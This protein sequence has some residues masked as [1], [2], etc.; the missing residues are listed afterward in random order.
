MV[1][2]VIKENGLQKVGFALTTKSVSQLQERVRPLRKLQIGSVG[3]VKLY[4]I[5][6]GR[7]RSLPF[8]SGSTYLSVA[9][10]WTCDPVKRTLSESKAE[11]K[12]PTKHNLAFTT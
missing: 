11:A 5:A 7:F 1:I 2:R 6:I 8:S 9:S 10:E 3:G 12:V 4:I